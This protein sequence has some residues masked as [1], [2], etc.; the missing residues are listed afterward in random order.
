[1]DR[2]L[3]SIRVVSPGEGVQRIEA[4]CANCGLVAAAEKWSRAMTEAAG[5]QHQ[6]LRVTGVMS[7]TEWD[8]MPRHYRSTRPRRSYGFYAE[9]HALHHDADGATI[10]VPVELRS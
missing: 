2:R 8:R 5:H 1:M 7:R 10:L 4:V 6:P 9:H 3:R